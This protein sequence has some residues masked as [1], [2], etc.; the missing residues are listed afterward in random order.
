MEKLSSTPPHGLFFP[1]CVC[2]SLSL[3]ANGCIIL[4]PQG[5]DGL[6]PLSLN[7]HFDPLSLHPLFF[8]SHQAASPHRECLSHFPLSLLRP[9]Q[10]PSWAGESSWHHMKA[11]P[12]ENP[13]G[14]KSCPH[15]QPWPRVPEHR[16][17]ETWPQCSPGER[18]QPRATQERSLPCAPP[19]CWVHGWVEKG[20]LPRNT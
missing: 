10:G 8:P 17:T 3:G 1:G 9:C 19:S 13:H 6:P 4:L 12:A 18:K 5:H 16:A 7:E 15:P 2:Q 20:A 11:L 14:T